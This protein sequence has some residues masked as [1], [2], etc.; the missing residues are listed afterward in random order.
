MRIVDELVLLGQRD[1][2]WNVHRMGQRWILRRCDAIAKRFHGSRPAG[3][4]AIAWIVLG[5]SVVQHSFQ[6][7]RGQHCCDDSR[8]VEGSY[9]QKKKFS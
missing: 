2:L 8:N 7:G 4:P 6:G 5:T 9:L 3:I 1:V